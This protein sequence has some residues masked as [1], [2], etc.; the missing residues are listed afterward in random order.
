MVSGSVIRYL[1]A[2]WVE[3]ESR[4]T[5]ADQCGQL[6]RNL[7]RLLRFGRLKIEWLVRGRTDQILI[8]RR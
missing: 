1:P 6:R 3:T 7:W 4:A 2:D 5:C 8:E